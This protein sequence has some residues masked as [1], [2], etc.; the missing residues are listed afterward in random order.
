MKNRYTFSPLAKKI[1]KDIDEH[2]GRAFL[3]GGIVRD[4]LIYN[5]VDYH[6]VDVEVYG[7]SVD[8]LEELLANYGNVNS[9]GKS[10]GIL[11]LDVLPNFDVALP[12]TEIKTGESHQDFDVTVNQNLDL[13]VAASRRDLT[14]NALM[15]EIKTGKIYDF[16]HGQEDIEKRTLRM[17]SET[18]FIEDPLR[19]L[20]TAQFA[21]RLDFCIETATKLMCKKMVQNKSLDK[22]SKERVFQEYSKLL[23]SQQ[24][25]I[26]LTFLK[27][28]KALWPCL[29]VLSKTMQRLDYHPEGDVWRHTLLVTDLAALCCHKTSN[30]L[31]FMWSALLHDIGKA[32]VTTKDGHAPGHN[33]AGVKIFNQEVKA[34]IPDKQLQKYIKTMI[35]YHMHLMNMVRNEAKDYSYFK[36]LKGIDGIVT[37]EDLILIT[38]CDKLGRYK[39]EHENINR[40][41]YVMKE[42][43]ARLSTKAQLPL[44]DGYDL[45]AL[46]IE[47][48]SKYSELLDWAYDLQLRGH[49]KAAILKMV[50]GR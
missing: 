6:D 49:S 9:I 27:E 14:I 3:V 33:E 29:D 40:F 18:T 17:V 19:V 28:I 13:K 8:E 25:S 4:M 12:R 43:M 20:R 24:P 5:R 42:K 11:K 30:P 45:K 41:D 2:H 36:I 1:F 46:G 47:P 26:G 10:F 50:E 37:I 39:D 7:L 48:S 32:T 34:F 16:F 23:L 15:Y 31:G 38:K 44:V 21:S 35:F 22:L